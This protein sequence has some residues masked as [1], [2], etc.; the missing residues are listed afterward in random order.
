MSLEH[1]ITKKS[2]LDMISRELRGR[3]CSSDGTR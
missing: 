3:A 1:L 2:D